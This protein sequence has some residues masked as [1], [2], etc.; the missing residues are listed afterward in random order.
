MNLNA[1]IAKAKR[2]LAE[3]EKSLNSNANRLIIC[4]EYT[5]ELTGE[6]V[7]ILSNTNQVELETT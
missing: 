3:K 5:K 2:L 7:V 4:T 1:A 6:L